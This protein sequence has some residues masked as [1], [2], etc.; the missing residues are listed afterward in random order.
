LD[1]VQLDLLRQQLGIDQQA[2]ANAIPA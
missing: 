1:R 2:Q